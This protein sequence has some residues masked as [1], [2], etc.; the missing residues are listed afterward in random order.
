MEFFLLIITGI[1]G[2]LIAG[3]LGLGGGVFYILVLPTII[4]WY[5]I[6]DDYI[7]AFVVSNSI[8]G[9]AFASGISILSQRKKLSSYM[10]ESLTMGI[11]AVVMSLL[12]TK[13][14]VHSSWFSKEV[15]NILVVILMIYILIRMILER[16]KEID[17]V[18]K[19]HEIEWKKGSISGAVT[20]FISALSGL[21]EV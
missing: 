20:G 12:V 11:P 1:I 17:T 6:P 3:L 13:Y 10:K 9:I 2:G 19:D 8:M 5:G 16:N 7:P 4:S 21:A 18:D 15:F 14:I